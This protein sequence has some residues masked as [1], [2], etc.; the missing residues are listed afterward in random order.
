MH[1][2]FS[3]TDNEEESNLK[4]YNV[5]NLTYVNQFFLITLEDTNLNNINIA[6][7]VKHV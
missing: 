5:D 4:G 7:K 2:A 1:K 6:L 3:F